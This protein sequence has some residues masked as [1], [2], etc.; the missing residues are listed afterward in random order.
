[1]RHCVLV[2]G[3]SHACEVGR[4]ELRDR[5]PPTKNVPADYD[6]DWVRLPARTVRREGSSG[7]SRS[8]RVRVDD[9]HLNSREQIPN[10][11][12]ML[13]AEFGQLERIRRSG[14]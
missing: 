8:G 5:K 2:G 13:E 12:K 4:D 6:P 7:R 14:R 3:L 10:V 9:S 11:P 1:M